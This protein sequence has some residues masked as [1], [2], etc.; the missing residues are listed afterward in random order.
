MEIQVHTQL[1]C[2]HF[3]FNK[4]FKFQT[5]RPDVWSDDTRMNALFAPFR[6][7]DLNPLHY[8]NKL[9]FWKE[10]ILAYC[11]ENEII[12][13]DLKTLENCF[14]RQKRKPKCLETVLAKMITD[15]NFQTRNELLRP[16]IGFALS[17]I[18]LYLS[19]SD[20]KLYFFQ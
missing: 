18:K 6:K 19:I 8:D 3:L 15:G 12:Q 1:Y 16:K 14:M 20:L 4:N 13:I 2:I 17:L 11:N 7:R 9:K 5:I 10:Q